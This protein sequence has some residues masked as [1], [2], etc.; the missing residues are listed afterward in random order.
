MYLSVLKAS[1]ICVGECRTIDEGLE[2]LRDPDLAATLLL[3]LYTAALVSRVASWR[4]SFR[5]VQG[6]LKT[7]EQVLDSKAG[8]WWSC[9]GAHHGSLSS[10]NENPGL[11]VIVTQLL[12]LVESQEYIAGTDEGA[13]IESIAALVGDLRKVY[14]WPTLAKMNARLLAEDA[15][16]RKERLASVWLQVGY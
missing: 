6:L 9:A 10:F 16:A 8:A 5:R 12:S 15:S 14:T 4:R 11:H 7:L 2:A 3:P 1:G 13:A